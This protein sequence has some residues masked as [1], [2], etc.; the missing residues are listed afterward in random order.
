MKVNEIIKVIDDIFPL[1]IQEEW[2]NSGK[3]VVFPS[4][5]VTGILIAL[6]TDNDVIEE[7]INNNC[8]FILTH[9]PLF[10]KSVK[11]IDSENPKSAMAIKLIN[12]EI[13]LYSC[14][15]NLDKIYYDKLGEKLGFKDGGLLLQSDLLENEIPVGFGSL[16]KL[17]RPIKFHDLIKKVKYVLD[18]DYL[19]YSGDV[20][21]DVKNIAFI[22]GAGGNMVDKIISLYQVD[23]II[24]GDVGYHHSKTALE[25]SVALIDAGHFGTEWLYLDFLKHEIQD[26]LTKKNK[27]TIVDIIIST[28][29]KNPHRLYI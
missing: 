21:K 23:C 2:D 28:K 20:E 13:S 14:H 16:S 25:N 19:I 15:T 7:A 22:N 3:Q 9:H 24:T 12:N 18:L 11:F 17:D 6:D 29:E 26:C 1:F 10:F 27:T 4:N 8:N 5:D